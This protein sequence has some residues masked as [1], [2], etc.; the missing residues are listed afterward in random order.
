MTGTKIFI[1]TL[2]TTVLVH[3]RG[4]TQLSVV[5]RVLANDALTVILVQICDE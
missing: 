4:L 1:L 5:V 3:Q 2:A